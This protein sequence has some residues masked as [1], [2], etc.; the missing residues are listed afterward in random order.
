MR[1]PCFSAPRAAEDVT[2]GLNANNSTQVAKAPLSSAPSQSPAFQTAAGP[3]DDGIV[4][5]SL[6]AQEQASS[7]SGSHSTQEAHSASSTSATPETVKAHELLSLNE[8]KNILQKL[9]EV[10]STPTV[11]LSEAAELLCKQ[12]SVPFVSIV[13]FDNS[14]AFI[15]LAVSGVAVCELEKNVVMTGTRW[16]A[17]WMLDKCGPLNK[18]V[19]NS[20]DTVG[21]PDD[22]LE[23][24][25][26]H[27]LNSFL[28][29]PIASGSQTIGMLTVA[30]EE[31]GAFD[32]HWFQ[33]MLEMLSVGLLV[34]LKHDHVL[35]LCRLMRQLDSAPDYL[36]VVTYL[37][38]GG[39]RVLLRSTNIK[40]GC[41][42]GLLN[43]DQSR[44]L[45]FESDTSKLKADEDSVNTGTPVD[46]H[47]TEIALENTLLLD[48]V[49]KGKARFV[50][51]CASYLQSCLK[52][53]TDIFISGAQMVASIVVLPLIYG[54]STLGGLYFT[55]EVTSN[56]Q[57]I[58]DLLM[59]FVN[60]LV[61]QLHQK[62]AH[63]VDV[64][65]DSIT[66]RPGTA[67]GGS[68]DGALNDGIAAS[69][70]V[71]S[72]SSDGADRSGMHTRVYVKRSCTEAML[73]VLQHEIRKTH[74]KS[75]A[76]EWVDELAL[77]ETI[78]KGGFGIVYKG[79][80]KGALAAVK[81][82]YARQ[83]E[84]QTMKDALEMAV[85]TTVAHPHIIQVYACFTDMVE[86][87][88]L[89][90]SMGSGGLS[91]PRE[92][93]GRTNV[94]FRKLQPEEDQSVATCNIV[95]MEYC[96]RG[97]LRHAMKKGVFHK[98]LGNSSIAVDL[99]AIVQVLIEVS[100]AIQHLHSVKLIHCDIKPENV[101]LKT[102][103]TKPLGFVTK[104]SD[105]GL[106]KLLRENYYIVNRS[107]SGTVTHLAPEL[108]QVGS[109]ITTA[110]DA[111][112]FGI[113]MWEL[114]TGQRVYSGLG[115]DAIIDRVY[116]KRSRPTFPQG[117]PSLYCELA[118]SCWEDEQA[119][120]PSFS[121]IVQ[122]LH[123]MLH[124][125]QLGTAAG[126]AGTGNGSSAGA[127]GSRG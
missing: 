9:A 107:G 97:S 30:K 78:G 101:L 35:Q 67:V 58:K 122:Q 3:A 20:A 90:G 44:A 36:A 81:V 64:I 95:A 25:K 87:A 22:W 4:G 46:L 115:R 56:F 94:R 14:T 72:A 53:A 8:V 71:G 70:A 113:M 7:A 123:D 61:L 33:K 68:V 41:R 108:F 51:D 54:G 18:S 43:S 117:V 47:I 45:V 92:G 5:K 121:T 85:L 49:T 28:A 16:S 80:W 19:F 69:A 27:S 63:N 11:A 112:S 120:R 29:L 82:M 84:R 119:Q 74:A 126:L 88:G 40:M 23:L 17:S 76:M 99:C 73:K 103:N 60:I 52:P 50:S 55:L 89:G 31:P 118:Q 93:G 13:G 6:P 1:C 66:Q 21:L 79:T 127:Y 15:L 34:H 98:R 48:A 39:H 62:L 26:K 102:D 96:D 59:G 111:F 106:A 12:L 125:F 116:K 42:L 91:S 105:F 57:N 75:Q 2:H 124:A 10:S 38:H 83:H 37:L 86:D 100:Q 32:D 24:H 114:Y 104:L 110:V 109:K 77:M 65:W